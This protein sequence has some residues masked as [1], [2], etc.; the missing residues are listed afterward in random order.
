MQDRD[1]G[2]DSRNIDAGLDQ[3]H[4]E[5][6]EKALWVRYA[7][8]IRHQPA[9][10]GALLRDDANRRIKRHM[11][12]LRFAGARPPSAG[13]LKAA[14]IRWIDRPRGLHELEALS[15]RPN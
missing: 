10:Y 7:A 6:F 9:D 5:V 11:F 13:D 4:S 3:A 14:P 15:L 2:G 12:L 1:A 8:T